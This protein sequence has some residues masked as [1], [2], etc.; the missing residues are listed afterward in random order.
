MKSRALPH[1]ADLPLGQHR[2]VEQ[3]CDP[4]DLEADPR[5][6]ER[7]LQIAQPALRLLDVGLEQVERVAEL[8]APVPHLGQLVL[9]EPLDLRRRET[10]ELLSLQRPVELPIASHVAEVQ[11]R[12]A[13][14]VILLRQRVAGREI[15][16]PV[17]DLELQIPEG[18]D[19]LLAR[20]PDERAR[21]HRRRAAP[22]CRG[23]TRGPAPCGRTLPA[24][25]GRPASACRPAP[26]PP[27]ARAPRAAGRADPSRRSG[28]GRPRGRSLPIGGTPRRPS[29]GPRSPPSRL[30]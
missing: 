26:R 2:A 3:V 13:R 9:D 10:V 21:A 22:G 5:E 20:R 16:H 1:L 25:R 23:R 7:A 14:G 6:P 17:P 18:V 15:P 28:A 30:Q 11:E 24:R 19:E 29:A 8:L 27:P 4:A 12:R